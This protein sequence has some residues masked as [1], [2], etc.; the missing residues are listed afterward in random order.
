MKKA[1]REFKGNVLPLYCY[2]R[3]RRYNM[4]VRLFWRSVWWYW[5]A[6]VSTTTLLMHFLI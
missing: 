4:Q 1:N 3:Q 6:D 2:C 5:I